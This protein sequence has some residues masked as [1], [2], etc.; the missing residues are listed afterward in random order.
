MH[1][2]MNDYFNII[3]LFDDI[4]ILKSIRFLLILLFY[5]FVS[6]IAFQNACTS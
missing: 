2:I 3:R 4:S 6:N 1:I 5:S